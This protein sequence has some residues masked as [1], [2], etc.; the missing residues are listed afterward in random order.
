MNPTLAIKKISYHSVT[1]KNLPFWKW[2]H[3]TVP[4]TVHTGIIKVLTV[5]NYMNNFPRWQW[6]Q[7]YGSKVKHFISR[8]LLSLAI[9]QTKNVIGVWQCWGFE[10]WYLRLKVILDPAWS[11]YILVHIVGSQ[12]WFTSVS[13]LERVVASVLGAAYISC[14]LLFNRRGFLTINATVL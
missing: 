8:S 14:C 5:Y 9:L 1:V 3:D 7:Q 12:I 6:M 13:R 10:K 2:L 11:F 4:N